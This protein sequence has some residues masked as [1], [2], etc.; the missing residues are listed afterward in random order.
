MASREK[1]IFWVVSLFIMAGVAGYLFC[2]HPLAEGGDMRKSTV[3]SGGNPAF[4]FTFEY[5]IAGWSLDESQG[6]TEKYDALYLRGSVDESTRFRTLIE[7]VVKPLPATGGPAELLGA[8]LKRAGNRPKF[9]VLNQREVD[10]GGEKAF[11]AIHESEARL[12]MED[13]KAKPVMIKQQTLFLARKDKLY[14]FS[15][16]SLAEPWKDH[17]AAF[18]M[19]LRTFKFKD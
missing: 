17:A 7:I 3:F 14:R 8:F 16:H 12:P 4:N 1:S 18:E 19:V 10:L 2:N 6:R 13:L 9:K 5:P 15:L 11:S